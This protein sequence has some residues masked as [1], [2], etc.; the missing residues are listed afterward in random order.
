MH[1]ESELWLL[2][3]THISYGR[4]N[5]SHNLLGD[6]EH[7]SVDRNGLEMTHHVTHRRTAKGPLLPTMID[8]L[9][10]QLTYLVPKVICLIHQHFNLLTT[11]KNLRMTAKTISC[12]QQ[13]VRTQ[14]AYKY[15]VRHCNGFTKGAKAQRVGLDQ[16][17]E[18]GDPHLLN[19]V[20]HDAL[21][22]RNL[23]FNFR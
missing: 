11:I 23:G 22:F 20:H 3:K 14:P 9:V 8:S 5:T 17:R 18:W 1:K 16:L 19:V 15:A 6:I 7:A 10:V 21:Y 13:L 12:T 2:S 4:K